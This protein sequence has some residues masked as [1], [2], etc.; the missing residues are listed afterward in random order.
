M[1]SENTMKKSYT[2]VI[3]FV[4]S[5]IL[6]LGFLMWRF[7]YILNSGNHVADLILGMILLCA[8][9][10]A[11]HHFG[12]FQALKYAAAWAGIFLALLVGYSYYED[13]SALTGK[14]KGNLLPFSATQNENGSV[15][16]MRSKDGH[17]QIEAYVNAVPVQ[18]MVDTGASKIALTIRDAKRLGIDVENLSYSEP[19]QTANGLTFGAFI[20]L[21]E[22]KVGS[23][24]VKDVSASVCQNLS[25]LSLLGMNFLKRLKGFK[26]E[27][28]RL[29]LEAPVS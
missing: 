11:I 2:G 27:G 26:I 13:I 16:F 10:P 29:T 21:S 5:G 3:T 20:H 4:I 7:P 8:V 15:S 19:M 28:N 18:F 1:S 22:L 23:L 6:L 9:A 24:T 12:S 17:F 25:G 14:V